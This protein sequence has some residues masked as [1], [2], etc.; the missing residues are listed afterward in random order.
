MSQI[1]G[2]ECR[3]FRNFWDCFRTVLA[4]FSGLF[5][6]NQGIIFKTVFG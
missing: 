3:N 1:F 4:K 6:D 5:S 2:T